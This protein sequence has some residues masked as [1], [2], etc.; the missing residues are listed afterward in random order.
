MYKILTKKIFKA[1]K[2]SPCQ[3]NRDLFEVAAELAIY[4]AF[5]MPNLRADRKSAVM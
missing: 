4:T 3:T 1:V 2:T 5:A